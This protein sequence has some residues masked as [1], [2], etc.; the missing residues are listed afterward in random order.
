MKGTTSRINVMMKHTR[1][2][3]LTTGCIPRVALLWVRSHCQSVDNNSGTKTANI[4]FPRRKVNHASS[5]CFDMGP[6]C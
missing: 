6:L 4:N 2:I 5:A 1:R 3:W